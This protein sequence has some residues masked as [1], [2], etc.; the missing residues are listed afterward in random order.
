MAVKI[1]TTI[2]WGMTPCSLTERKCDLSVINI[3]TDIVFTVGN[4]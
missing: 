3:M 4:S 2:L 1:N